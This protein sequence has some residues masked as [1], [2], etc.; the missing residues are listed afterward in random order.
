MW[1]RVCPECGTGYVR[2][3]GNMGSDVC[4]ECGTR[5]VLNMDM[6]YPLKVGNIGQDVCVLNGDIGC[7]LN[8]EWC[9]S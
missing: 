4:P 7:V 6:V 9:V 8:M 3:C 5:C 1:D 2:V